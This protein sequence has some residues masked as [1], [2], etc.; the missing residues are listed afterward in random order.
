MKELYKPKS[1]QFPSHICLV[2][3]SSPVPMVDFSKFIAPISLYESAMSFQVQNEILSAVKRVGVMVDKEELLKALDYDRNQYAEGYK[4][5]YEAAAS[6]WISVEG[7]P[8]EEDGMSVLCV[9]KTYWGTCVCEGYYSK[10]GNRVWP[11]DEDIALD[12]VTHWMPMPEPPEE[13]I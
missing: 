2:D 9:V 5:G 3:C 12:D 7:N 1:K 13:E 10:I 8:P 6:K 11:K 4:A